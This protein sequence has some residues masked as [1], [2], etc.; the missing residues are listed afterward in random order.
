ME[1]RLERARGGTRRSVGKILQQSQEVI[2]V[3]IKIVRIYFIKK[4]TNPNGLVSNLST[5]HLQ[6][7]SPFLNGSSRSPRAGFHWPRMDH[8]TTIVTLIGSA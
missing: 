7:R 3:L 8:V 4:Q 5:Q 6:G 1:R 2:S